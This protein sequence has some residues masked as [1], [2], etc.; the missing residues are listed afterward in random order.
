MG[1]GTEIGGCSESASSWY[2]ASRHDE[3]DAQHTSSSTESAAPEPG[4]TSQ[5]RSA[6][7]SSEGSG[8]ARRRQPCGVAARQT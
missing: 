6:A 1:V 2:S 3:R 4:W 5:T 8:E 7:A